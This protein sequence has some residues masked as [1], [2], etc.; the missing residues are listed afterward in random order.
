MLLSINVHHLLRWREEEEAKKKEQ[1]VICASGLWNSNASTKHYFNIYII[2]FA[3]VMCI[4]ER[5]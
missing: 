1:G 2:V 5:D 4:C 3:I